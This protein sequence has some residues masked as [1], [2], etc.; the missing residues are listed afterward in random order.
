MQALLVFILYVRCTAI[1]PADPGIMS[2]FEYGVSNKPH[3]DN[4]LST[5]DLPRKFDEFG[6]ELHSSPSS[7]SRS[8][9][10]AP[11]SSRKG[12]VEDVGRDD[13][14]RE[15]DGH[16]A[17]NGIGNILCALFIYED[18]RKHDDAAE[19]QGSCEDA[20]FCTLC[21]SEVSQNKICC[22]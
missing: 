13:A 7:I 14:L 10:A 22:C 12:S 5:K 15:I 9:I 6:S 11:N 4:N 21:K 19:Q 8:S 17:R 3:A 1:N 18:C 2:K 16:R 20:L